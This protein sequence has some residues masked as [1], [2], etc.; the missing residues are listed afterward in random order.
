MKARRWVALA[1]AGVAGVLVSVLVNVVSTPAASAHGAMMKPGSR[2]FLCWKDGL[3]P[4]GDIR[5]QNP[6][7][8]AAVTAGGTNSLY[9]W[10]GVL[11]SDGGGR[12]KG[13]IPDGK[14]CSGGNP[15]FSGFDIARNDYPVTHL[16][17]GANIRWS[18]NMWAAHPGTFHLYVT[19]DSWS[20]TRALSWD[21]LESTPF[22]SVT[23]P[24]ASGS[25]GT[26]D[27]QYYWNANLPSGKSGRH[28]IYSVW[29]RSDS[30]ET[31][32]NCSDVTFD[33]GNGQETG[34]GGGGGSSTTTTTTTTTTGT[35]TSTTSTTPT[36]T[37]SNPGT[38]GCTANYRI[39]SSWSGGF[40]GEVEVVNTGSSTFSGW[41][42]RWNLASG[43]TL[44]SVWNGV[45]S[46]SGSEV[47]VSNVDWNRTVA[48][49]GSAKFGFTGSYTGSNP[50]PTVTCTSP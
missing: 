33:G 14:L 36:T 11:R 47:A 24:P 18:Y 29:T 13:F 5:P 22:H 3:S 2:T 49:S 10:F 39:T 26:V 40:Q 4:Q 20:P 43:Q 38:T 35:T 21:D 44:N 12:T 19:K 25:V 48:P 17:A 8:S 15:T 7:C 32:Y 16:T 6:A 31:F 28:I 45:R 34:V 27:G 50:L 23:N 41:T 46:G 42:A 9:N 30:Q 37:S 1:A